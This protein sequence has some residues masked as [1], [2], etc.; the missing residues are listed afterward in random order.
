MCIASNGL[1]Q[2]GKQD[3][4]NMPSQLPGASEAIGFD[5]LNEHWTWK[6]FI[7]LASAAGDKTIFLFLACPA[8]CLA[9]TLLDIF[10]RLY[11]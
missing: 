7:Q 10:Q 11:C 2:K 9:C 3:V 8:C 6:V 1:M 5:S 4:V